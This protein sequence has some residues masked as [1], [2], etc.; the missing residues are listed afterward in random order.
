LRQL[1]DWLNEYA[2]SHQHPTNQL[3][4]KICV[5]LITFSVIGLL[6]C[7]PVPEIFKQ[8][9]QLN[10]GN[11]FVVACLAFYLSLSFKMFIGMA[12]QT[13]LMI[14][15]IFKLN[16]QGNLFVISLGIF[17]V[18]WIFQFIGH[19]MEGKK[20]SFFKDLLFLLIG[21]LW[22]LKFLF[23]KFGLEK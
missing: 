5:P 12:I 18:A 10:W 9:G 20:P 4:H 6:W 17:I 3:I 11:L 8:A 23:S 2:E 7:I 1:N 21:P 16:E 14:A 15:I 13:A 19:K 22:V